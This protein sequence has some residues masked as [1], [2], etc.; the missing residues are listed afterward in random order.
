MIYKVTKPLQRDATKGNSFIINY[1]IF[2][3]YPPHKLFGIIGLNTCLM[4]HF[5]AT[6]INQYC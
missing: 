3:K 6:V 5:F 4:V 1:N 2:K